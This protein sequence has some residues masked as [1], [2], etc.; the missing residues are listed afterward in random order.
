M[1]GREKPPRTP[2][3]RYG[4]T[5]ARI[6]GKPGHV[7]GPMDGAAIAAIK[8]HLGGDEALAAIGA[9][10]FVADHDDLSFQLS[11]PSPN[12]AHVIVISREPR[13]FFGMHCYGR[14]PAARAAAPLIGAAREIL[15]ENLATVLGKLAGIEALHHRHF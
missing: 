5:A 12:G 7:E 1:T 11:P 10:G 2:A 9:H 4:L 13:G 8:A 14:A 6:A 3:V 15:P